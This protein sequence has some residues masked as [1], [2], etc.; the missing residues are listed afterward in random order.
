M[1]MTTFAE[2]FDFTGKTVF[3]FVTYAVSGLGATVR[4]YTAACP[5]A[6]IGEGLAVRGEEVRDTG[7]EVEA[8]LR[9][10]NLLI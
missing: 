7:A 9:R 6:T 10:V 4:N 8:W 5:G 1:I 2:G 3:P